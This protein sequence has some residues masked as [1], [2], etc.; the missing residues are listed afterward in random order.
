M[1][2]PRQYDAAETPKSPEDIPLEAEGATGTKMLQAWK[3]Q[4][5]PYVCSYG[6]YI[7]SEFN[8]I[9]FFFLWVLVCKTIFSVLYRDGHTANANI[10]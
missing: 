5:I 9:V 4:T 8:A 6:S 7:K 3:L 10:I 1:T 2:C